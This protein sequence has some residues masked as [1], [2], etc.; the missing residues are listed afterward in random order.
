MRNKI[1]LFALST[2]AGFTAF[3]AAIGTV[4][5]FVNY[6]EFSDIKIDG[7]SFGAYFAYGDGLPY[8]EDGEGNIIH[9]PYGIKTQRHLYNLAWLQYSGKFNQDEDED[10]EIDQQFYFVIDPSLVETG[11]DMTGWILPPIGT[12][13]YPFLGN[14]EGNGVTISNLTVSN[15]ETFTATDTYPYGSKPTKI[16]RMSVTRRLTA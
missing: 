13:T 12:E 15:K 8:E 14:F 10:G 4:A 1:K 16:W 7:S 5:W 9:Q 6:V 3:C 2:L 11:L